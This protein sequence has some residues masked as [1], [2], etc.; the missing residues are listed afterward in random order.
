MGCAMDL[1]IEHTAHTPSHLCVY[2]HTYITQKMQLYTL[3]MHVCK[4]IRITQML[5]KGAE[6]I[7]YPISDTGQAMSGDL[8][9]Q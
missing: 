5:Q 7:G 4:H 2:I 8:A 9:R 6:L 3:H 1:T